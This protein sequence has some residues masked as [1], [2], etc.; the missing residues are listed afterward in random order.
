MVLRG[1]SPDADHFLERVR[2]SHDGQLFLTG[3]FPH[4]PVTDIDHCISVDKF[5]F[6]MPVTRENGRHV[7]RAV[8]S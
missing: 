6:A 3:N 4:A 7:M 8:R 1:N 2:N 5:F